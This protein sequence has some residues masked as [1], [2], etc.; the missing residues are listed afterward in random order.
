MKW[1]FDGDGAWDAYSA[2]HD[3]GNPFVWRIVVC[4]DG[5][6][7]VSQSASE[8]TDRKECFPTLAGAKAFCE[9]RESSFSL[10]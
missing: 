7:D 4:E 8:L 3:D 2:Q 9:R 5:T 1:E 10:A 6:F